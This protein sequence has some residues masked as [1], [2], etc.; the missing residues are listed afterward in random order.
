MLNA[1]KMTCFSPSLL[2]AKFVTYM[3][4]STILQTESNLV[5]QNEKS[6]NWGTEMKLTS[7]LKGQSTFF[8]QINWNWNFLLQ[9]LGTS[10]VIG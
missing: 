10:D 6:Q 4:K 7:N 5:I 8:F 1:N 2:T 9:Y 3:D